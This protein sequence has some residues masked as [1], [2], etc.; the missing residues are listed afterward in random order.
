M[1]LNDTYTYYATLLYEWIS[2]LV[3]H[4]CIYHIHGNYRVVVNHAVMQ[5]RIQYF[6]GSQLSLL[7]YLCIGSSLF[8]ISS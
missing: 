8:L 4:V 6:H 7:S 3:Q 1:V 5:Y 2:Q